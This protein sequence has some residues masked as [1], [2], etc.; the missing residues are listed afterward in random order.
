M[1]LIRN[2]LDLTIIPEVHRRTLVWIHGF[3]DTAELFCQDFLQEPLVED[4][5][6][7]LPTAEESRR[8]SETVRSWYTRSAGYS[9]NSSAEG[10]ISRICGIL[11]EEAK[12]TD[13]LMIGGFSQGAVM[14]LVCG[15]CRYSGNISAIIGLSGFMMNVPVPQ[16]RKRIPVLLYHG[17]NDNRIPLAE[18]RQSYEKYLK[19]VNFHLE[20]H[21][22][23]PHEVYLE[24]YQFIRQWIRTVLNLNN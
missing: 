24:E 16:E 6:I 1:Q 14:S 21:P 11:E 18:A 12:H 5:K 20:V 15:L 23:M 10:S 13:C 19:G 9:F 3:N 22:T 17:R 8:G 2:G 7:V 4:C